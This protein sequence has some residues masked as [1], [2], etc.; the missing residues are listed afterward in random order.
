M[1]ATAM[2]QHDPGAPPNPPLPKVYTE[3]RF[4]LP[5][6]N[7]KGQWLIGR[8][9]ER[10]PSSEG[11][12]VNWLRGLIVVGS[13]DYL[14][15]RTDHAFMLAQV[16]KEPLVKL[17][18]VVEQFVLCENDHE[19]EGAYLY[20]V[21]AQWARGMGACELRIETQTDVHRDAIKG[22]IGKLWQRDQIFSKLD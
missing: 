13:N 16:T 8:L 11:E 10:Y 18:I 1:P 20:T 4:H 5:D 9:Q 2:K 15:V 6:L 19:D 12:L 21:M 7:E 17:P 14:F 3:R 22:R